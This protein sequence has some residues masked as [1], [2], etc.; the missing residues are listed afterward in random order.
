MIGLGMDSVVPFTEEST[1]RA[2][3]GVVQS[4]V[5][6]IVAIRSGLPDAARAAPTNAV[7][8]MQKAWGCQVNS[9]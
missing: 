7:Y 8:R 9:P 6:D 1:D 4:S 5:L 3:S 2:E